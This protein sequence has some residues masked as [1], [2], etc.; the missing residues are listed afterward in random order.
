[1]PGTSNQGI[2][3]QENLGVVL[4]V[5]RCICFDDSRHTEVQSRLLFLGLADWPLLFVRLVR[6]VIHEYLLCIDSR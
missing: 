5:A 2:F 1:M 6:K 3:K 4:Q